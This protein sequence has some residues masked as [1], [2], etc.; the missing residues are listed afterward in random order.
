MLGIDIA[1]KYIGLKEDKDNKVLKDF[2]KSHGHD[3]A[4]DPDV[5]AWCSAFVN[6]CEREVGNKGTGLLNARS[7]LKYGKPVDLKDAQYG[8]IV[9]F[10]RGNNNWQGHVAYYSDLEVSKKGT[11]IITVG[12][13]QSDSVSY[14]YYSVDSLLGVRRP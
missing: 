14:G 8:D 10:K 9:I 11:T 7:F 13:N 3:I 6:A 2:L 1:K 5:I 12:G 4:I